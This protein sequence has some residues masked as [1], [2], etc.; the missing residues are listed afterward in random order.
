VQDFPQ[1]AAGM[2]GGKSVRGEKRKDAQ[3]D[4]RGNPRAELVR[5]SGAHRLMNGW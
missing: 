2:V 3:P 1:N 5:R 4:Q